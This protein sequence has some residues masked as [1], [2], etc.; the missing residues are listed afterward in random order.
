[1]DHRKNNLHKILRSAEGEKKN[2]REMEEKA[3]E[4][5]NGRYGGGGK[6]EYYHE[7]FGR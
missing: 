6:E 5:L 3:I 4:F 7:K 1:V 2:Q